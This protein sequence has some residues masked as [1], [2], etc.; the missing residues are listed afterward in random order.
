MARTY[1][2]IPAHSADG[3]ESPYRH[4]RRVP[5]GWEIP[6]LWGTLDGAAITARTEAKAT[7]RALRRE[8]REM[9]KAPR[10]DEWG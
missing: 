3:T 8:V 4:G 5:G 7:K 2:T 9:N 1:R 6:D 10:S